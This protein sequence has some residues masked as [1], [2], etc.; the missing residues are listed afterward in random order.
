MKH[1]ET[2]AGN[3]RLESAIE[4]AIERAFLTAHLL[5][6][7]IQQAESAVTGAIESLDTGDGSEETLFRNAIQRAARHASSEAVQGALPARAGLRAVLNLSP[8]LRGCYVLRILAGF[9]RHDCARLLGL[10]VPQVEHFTCAAFERLA[11]A[12]SPPIFSET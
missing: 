11:A 3:S 7:N 8:N 1:N 4:R 9:S 12:G 10:N 6:G 2:G 5:T